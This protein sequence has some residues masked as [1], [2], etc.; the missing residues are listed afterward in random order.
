MTS[1]VRIKNSLRKAA[2]KAEGLKPHQIEAMSMNA[3]A[4]I[5]TMEEELGVAWS[6]LSKMERGLS[7]SYDLIGNT[8]NQM[9]ALFRDNT[10]PEQPKNGKRRRRNSRR[11][12]SH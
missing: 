3:L 9:G 6:V 12:A 5:E 11:R 4:L 1:T 2:M 10:P 8:Y 7:K